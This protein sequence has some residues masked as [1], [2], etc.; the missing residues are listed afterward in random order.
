MKFKEKNQPFETFIAQKNPLDI[1]SFQ[2]N[3][4]NKKKPSTENKKQFIS[5][6][7]FDQK[8]KDSDL[9]KEN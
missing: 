1:Q 5:N 3:L 7:I 8:T 4:F 6:K 2:P 9:E